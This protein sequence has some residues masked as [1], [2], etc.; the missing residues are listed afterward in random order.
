MSNY[1]IPIEPVPTNTLPSRRERLQVLMRLKS[2][3]QLLIIGVTLT[4]MV[5][6]ILL[7][8][9]LRERAAPEII[10]L[11]KGMASIEAEP[12][13]AYEPIPAGDEQHLGMGEASYYGAGFAG[14]LTANGEIFNPAEMTA[15]H[16]TLPMGSKVRVTN[17]A[18]GET[19]IVRINDRGPY[20]GNR[21][22]DLSEAAARE[23]GLIRSGVGQVRLALVT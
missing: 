14:N 19:V 10:P 3:R 11:G 8:I 23:I 18:N 7:A 1:I 20:H 6:G 9:I 16:R 2:Q 4:A 13:T 12:L 21:V 15:A 17:P 5:A 22:I